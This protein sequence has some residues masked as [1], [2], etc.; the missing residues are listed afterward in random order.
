[1]ENKKINIAELLKDCP[2]GME[3][4]CTT[5]ENVTFEEVRN[6]TIIIVRNNKQPY[7]DK[8]ALN[9]YGRITPYE[10]E[11]CRI[12]PKGK[13]TWEGFHRPFKD[14]D[15]ISVIINKDLWYGI[16]QKELNT[17]LYS[18]VSYSNSSECLYHSRSASMCRIGDIVEIRLATEEEKQKLFDS[19]K[20]N[21]Y[22]WNAEAKTLEKL[23]K[24]KDG[25]ILA[26]DDTVYIYNGIE[27]LSPY[28]RHYV[29]VIADKNGLFSINTSSKKYGTRLATEEEKQELFQAIKANGYHWNEETKT[30]EKL[31]KPKFKV[32]DRITNGKTSIKIGYIDDEYYYEISRNIA[33]R[34]LI[35][36]QDEWELVPNKFDI[37]KL[38]PFDKVLVRDFDNEVWDVDFFSRLL[39]GKHFKCL[40]SSYVQCIPYKGNEYLHNSTD[41]CND[42][43]KTW[44]K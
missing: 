26:I 9:K 37:L 22:K 1:M 34:L 15:I 24:F 6:D 14:G 18:Y 23:P 11:K 10:D 25:D 44:E 33:S 36:N 13:T 35:K 32:G 21:G 19:I 7:V 40:G 2:K 16:Y 43:F 3:L 8:V 4:D 42:Y 39:D 27:E 28:R 29:Y 17:I 38:K 31:I 41:T 12:F 20:A 30:L 5:W